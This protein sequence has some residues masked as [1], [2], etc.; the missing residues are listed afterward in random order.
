[1]MS[2]QPGLKPKLHALYGPLYGLGGRVGFVGLPS[3][4]T[5]VRRVNAVRCVFEEPQTLP[6]GLWGGGGDSGSKG[7][8]PYGIQV[9][10]HPVPESGRIC[11]L[12]SVFI[13]SVQLSCSS[14]SSSSFFSESIVDVQCVASFCYTVK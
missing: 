10:G 1:M 13:L 9:C 11:R 4:Q 8:E 14:S 12:D 7:E 3:F 6:A 5:F 2:N